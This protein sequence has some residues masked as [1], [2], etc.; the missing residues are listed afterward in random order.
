[1]KKVGSNSS[2]YSDTTKSKTFLS[3]KNVKITK[4]V[5]AFKG[6]ANTYNVEILNSFNDLKILNLQLQ[7]SQ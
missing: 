6:Y 7:V 1:M 3:K 5:H 2:L 4:R